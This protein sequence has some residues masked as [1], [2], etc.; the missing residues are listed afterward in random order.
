M[1]LISNPRGENQAA[2]VPEW[3]WRLTC[4]ED[5]NGDEEGVFRLVQMQIVH[6][7]RE[8]KDRI[9]EFELKP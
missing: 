3:R 5:V 7:L 8:L 2:N 6:P 1:R 9:D 4:R